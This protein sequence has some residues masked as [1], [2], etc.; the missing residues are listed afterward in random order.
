MLNHIKAGQMAE[1][2]NAP[3][4]KTGMGASPSRVRIPVCP[5][6]LSPFTNIFKKQV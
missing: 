2:L 5:P 3:V 1:W 4:L 6:L